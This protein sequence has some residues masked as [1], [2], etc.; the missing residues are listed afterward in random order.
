MTD[1]VEA[2]P[3]KRAVNT[4]FALIGLPGA[5]G[6]LWAAIAYD[7]SFETGR[8]GGLLTLL[9]VAAGGDWAARVLFALAALWAA[10]LGLGGLWRWLDKRPMVIADDAGVRLHP[11][12]C[13]EPL[14]WSQIER[15]LVHDR[16]PAVLEFRLNRRIWAVE[17]PLSARR[18]RMALPTMGLSYREAQRLV[19][20]LNRLRRDAR[21]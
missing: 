14:A 5:I 7:Q 15:I 18:V 10:S 20:D 17:T 19:V 16:R 3:S 13:M 4:I 11:A 21:R 6:F 9:R 1:A 8:W 12:Y 2:P